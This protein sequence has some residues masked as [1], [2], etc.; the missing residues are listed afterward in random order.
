MKA[1]IMA[2]SD[3]GK[4]AGKKGEKKAD[5]KADKKAGKTKGSK[6]ESVIAKAGKIAGNALVEEIVAAALVAAAAAIRDPKKARA[7]AAATGDELK[8]LTKG[9]A[10]EGSALWSL[11]LE[12]ARGAIDSHHSAKPA[13]AITPKSVSSAKKT[14]K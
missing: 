11:A 4:K 14:G 7:V 1:G 2:K 13:E 12:V 8:V 5:K 9:A 6:T 3:K 10:K